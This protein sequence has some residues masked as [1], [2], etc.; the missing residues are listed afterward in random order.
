MQEA[1]R[2]VAR[3]PGHWMEIAVVFFSPTKLT[4]ATNQLVI[5]FSHSKLASVTASIT[6]RDQRY[7]R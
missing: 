1:G 4:P 2:A 5:F 3:Q 6:E 7:G